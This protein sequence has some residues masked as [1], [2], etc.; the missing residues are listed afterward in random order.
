MSFRRERVYPIGAAAIFA[1]VVTLGMATGC[2]KHT[3]EPGFSDLGRTQVQ[4]FAPPGA[5]V[6]V[7]DCPPRSHEIA[8]YGPYGNRLE[9]APEEFCTFNLPPGRYL[10]KYTAAE[11]LPGASIYGE[12]D[13]KYANSKEA[14]YF[15]KLAFVPISL[16][17]EYYRKVEI[18]GNEIFPYRGE[19]YRTAVDENDLQRLQQGDVVEKVFFVADLEKAACTRDKLTR[20][21]RVMERKMEYAD[22]RFRD[23]Y[24]DFR[25]D[26]SDSMANFWGTDRQ[27]IRWEKERQELGIKYEHMRKR[28][29][30]TQD[31]LKGDT[32]LIRKGMLALAT[33]EI[34][35]QHKDMESAADDLGEIMLIMR[36][37]GRHMQWGDPRRELASSGKD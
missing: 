13:V 6:T 27:Y 37:G 9:Q 4:F 15:Q 29:A 14:S 22:A 26:V 28:L 10:F 12:L 30:R 8:T 17:S 19:A 3:M 16:P 35:Q 25:I 34:V 23:A 5:T 2:S 24:Q 31:L 20:D 36:I 21:L 18:N 7:K 1:A 33:A 32:V 11:G